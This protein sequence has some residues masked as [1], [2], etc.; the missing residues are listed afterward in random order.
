MRVLVPGWDAPANALEF[1]RELQRLESDELY[2]FDF[3][4]VS[5]VTPGW[6]VVVGEALRVFRDTHEGA[7]RR[8][9]NYKHLGYAAHVGFFKYFG[10]TYGLAPAQA[11]GSRTYVPI[12]IVNVRDIKERAA[13][14]FLHPGEVVEGE[15]RR[16]AQLLGQQQDGA[17]IDTLTYS[18][19]EIVR[20]VVEHSNSPSY[21]I[22]AQY[23]PG[24]DTAELAVADSGCGILASLVENPKLRIDNDLDALK[25]ALLPGISSK[26]WR[27]SNSDDVWAN[28]GYG[29]FMTQRLCSL[30][31]EFTLLSGHSG[32]RAVGDKINELHANA[33]GTVVILKM[34]TGIINNL[35]S[36][37]SDFRE[38]GR[39]L[40][41]KVGGANRFGPSLASQVLRPATP[42]ATK[43]Q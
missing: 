1:G 39:Q 38:E 41:K 15:S 24:Q 30:G 21:T 12:T 9:L 32:L 23:W 4:N 35:S 34:N 11:E 6:L 25:L 14:G 33:Q 20:N 16:L 42:Q 8:A 28:S 37:L 27:R 43:R 3:Q 18:I 2:E 10:M 36:R 31:G 22:A 7:K 26:A 40:A 19:R 13:N 17:L 5:F 29:L